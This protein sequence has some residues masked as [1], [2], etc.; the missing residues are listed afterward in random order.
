MKTIAVLL[1]VFNRK[2][3]TIQCLKR[4][5]NILPL[6][7]YL[8]DVYLT[9][10]SASAFYLQAVTI[11]DNLYLAIEQSCFWPNNDNVVSTRYIERSTFKE[12]TTK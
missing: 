3:K 5:Y 6:E 11:T 1:T 9:D 4:L 10:D 8:V 2:E 12:S 7:G